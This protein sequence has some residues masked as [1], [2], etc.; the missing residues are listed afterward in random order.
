MEDYKSNKLYKKMDSDTVISET[1]KQYKEHF[2]SLF[3]I[4]FITNIIL[5]FPAYYFKL[6]D[7]EI[8][9]NQDLSIIKQF[10]INVFIFLVIALLIYTLSNA[11]ICNYIYKAGYK[12]VSLSNIINESIVK[13]YL[14]FLVTIILAS[15]I[16]S[17]GTGISVIFIFIGIFI[18]LLYLGT[19]LIPAGSCVIIENLN[20]FEAINRSFILSHRDFWG[21]LGALLLLVIL[22]IILAI[23]VSMITLL[24]FAFEVFAELSKGYNLLDII[25]NEEL[26]ETKITT[27]G[28][29]MNIIFSSFTFPIFPIFSVVLYFKLKHKE[30]N[31]ESKFESRPY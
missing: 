18:A 2:I 23:V 16:L 15:I 25:Q 27:V 17:F 3:M 20:P 9:L 4:S 24:P 22:F 11:I 14:K 7:H 29:F 30:D 12:K 10:I 8:Y 13:Y 6:F 31:L 1:F 5:F 26:F 28:I 21:A 19:V